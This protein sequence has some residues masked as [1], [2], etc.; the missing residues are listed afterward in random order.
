M[1]D[2]SWGTI[3]WMPMVDIFLSVDNGI[4]WENIGSDIS[5]NGKFRWWNNLIVGE[6]FYIKIADSYDVNSSTVIGPC[7]VI[8]NTTPI[9]ELSTDNLNFITGKNEIDFSIKNIGGGLLKW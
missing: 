4:T 5:N 7:D 2:I 8:E 3:G 9:I 1:L 6:K